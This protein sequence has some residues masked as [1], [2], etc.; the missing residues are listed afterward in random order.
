MEQVK[1][2]IAGKTYYLAQ[3]GLVSLE[4]RTTWQVGRC[5]PTEV[6]E[7]ICDGAHV[8]KIP[9]HLDGARVFNAAASLGKPVAEITEEIRFRDVLLV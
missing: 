9:V 4:T 1:R 3:T 5:Y 2:K 7:E 8:Q 6:A